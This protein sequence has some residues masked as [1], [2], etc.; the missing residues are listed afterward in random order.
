M[1][2]TYGGLPIRICRVMNFTR[3]PVMSDDGTSYLCTK[4]TLEAVGIVNSQSDPLNPAVGLGQSNVRGAAGAPF[5]VADA[6]FPATNPALTD[7]VIRHW[8]SIPRRQLVIRG[9]A[10]TLLRSPKVG[11]VCDAKDGPFVE[12]YDVKEVFGDSRTFIVY[13]QVTTYLN[14]CEESEGIS[15]A[16]L[17]NRWSQYHELDPDH[18]LTI[19]T[20]GD[21]YFRTDL[22]RTLNINPDILRPFLFLP[23]PVGYQREHIKVWFPGSVGHLKY[24]M[25]DVQKSDHFVAGQ[26]VAASHIQATYREALQSDP[27]LVQTMLDGVDKYYQVKWLMDQ[28]K[29]D[30]RTHTG[31]GAIK[32]SDT[33]RVVKGAP[34][35]TPKPSP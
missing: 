23:I 34:K 17:S 9:A 16:L 12:T 8:L 35:R 25:I 22:V 18:G 20:S 3:Q 33:K 29:R 24:E 30:K 21:A 2:V 4:F 19:V 27:D 6:V 31:G 11:M 1:I 13:F 28:S 5:A 14:E 10:T 7:T 15:A 26:E 32:G